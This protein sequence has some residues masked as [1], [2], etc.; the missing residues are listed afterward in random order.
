[1][2]TFLGVLDTVLDITTMLFALLILVGLASIVVLYVLDVTQSKQT[3]RKNYPVIGRLRYVFEHLGVFFRQY[4]FAMDREELPFNRA[5]R[6][7]VARAAK[8]V[9]GTL[10]FGSTKPLN[11]PGDIFFLNGGFP[12]TAEEI[13]AHTPEPVIFG[14]GNA[15]HP[16]AAP[17]F[18]NISAMSYGALSGPAVSALSAGAHQSGI[19]LNTGEGGLSPFHQTA[20]CDLVFQIGTAKYGVRDQDGNLDPAKLTELAAHPAVQMFEIK[21]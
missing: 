7:W 17:S 11:R 3:I 9:D 13:A 1:M 4:F 20:P 10:A 8:N 18:F 21:L 15:R 14:D 2:E 16:Y 19:W 6:S 5:Q 12:P